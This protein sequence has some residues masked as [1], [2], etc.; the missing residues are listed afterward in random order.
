[1]QILYNTTEKGAREV[2]TYLWNN[3]LGGK[4]SSLPLGDAV[5]D[6]IDLDFEGGTNEHW[7][8]LAQFL[9]SYSKGGKK[10]YL[11]AAPEYPFLDA[12][13]GV[14]LKTACVW[15]QLYNFSQEDFLRSGFI[16]AD[17][18][19]KQVLPAI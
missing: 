19:T 4:S 3:F 2:A 11:S 5:L 10:V 9:S 6:G 12:W 16:P 13:L 8:D 7:N 18:L 17:D 15:V 1:M 14:A